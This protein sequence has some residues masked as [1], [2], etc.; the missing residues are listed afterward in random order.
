MPL[1]L[2]TV[3]QDILDWSKNFIEVPHPALGNWAPCPFARRARLS[4]AVKIVIGTEPYH[5]LCSF[6]QHGLGDS[7]V[8]IYAYDPADWKYTQFHNSLEQANVE[9]LLPMNLLALEDHPAEVELVNGVCMNHGQYALAMVQSLSKLNN[10][11]SDL[12]SKGFYHSW[13]EEYL[14]MLFKH[15]QDFK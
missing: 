1:N 11:A 13:P 2:E 3:K 8:V 6:S 10:S 9:C 7:E 12:A 5:D 14:T 4:G 15:R